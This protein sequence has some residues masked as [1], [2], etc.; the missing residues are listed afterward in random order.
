MKPSHLSRVL[1]IS[2]EPWDGHAVSK[3]HYAVTLARRGAE[4]YFL[5]PPDPQRREISVEPTA[6][7]RVWRV[8][9]PRVAPG[10]RFWP[11]SWR[12]AV[13]RR[14][15][16][17][18]ERQIGGTF[19]TVWLFENSRFYD[20]EFAGDRLRIYHQVDLNQNFH[21]ADAARSADI[22]FAVTEEI[23]I[24]LQSF[25]SKAF[26]I[27]HGVATY[28][29]TALT[30]MESS[31]FRHS[32]INAVYIGNLDIRYIDVPLLCAVVKRHLEVTFH[33]VGAYRPDGE[34]HSACR[35]L[36]NI[37]W[38]GKIESGK[39]PSL[40]E[41]GDINLLVYRFRAYPKQLANSHKI[42][43]YLASGNITVA[44]WTEE[45]RDNRH[46]LEMVERREEYVG[47]FSEVVNDLKHY[48]SAEKRRER[49][50]YA[51]DHSYD[52]Q[53]DRILELLKR[54][55]LVN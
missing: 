13:Q 22:C 14:W 43:E 18:L 3:H 12:V 11:R 55:N 35:T 24:R 44:T 19:D 7:E 33:F 51:A 26:K 25:N 37:V 41:H 27:Q 40:L 45:Y 34:L 50:A 52:R 47:R 42:M 48:N 38:W 4:V 28:S 2:P 30:E 39:I 10:L 15:L 9:A 16:R 32:G 21:V 54:Y 6:H 8:R 46:L 53:L 49:K 23:L 5:D 20:M 29:G 1:L 17:N 36:K 31:R